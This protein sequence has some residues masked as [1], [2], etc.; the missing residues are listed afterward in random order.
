M[1]AWNDTIFALSSGAPPS[2]VSVIRVS[3]PQTTVIL[4]ALA[5]EIP[6][7]PEPPSEAA[8]GGD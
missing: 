2:G 5:G 1:E 7:P 6:S 8:D 4:E 3:G